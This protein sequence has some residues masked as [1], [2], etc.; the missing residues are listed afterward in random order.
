MKDELEETIRKFL[1]AIIDAMLLVLMM[2]FAF[3]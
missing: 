2:A 1:M 3:S